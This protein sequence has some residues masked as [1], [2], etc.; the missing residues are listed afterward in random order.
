MLIK[1]FFFILSNITVPGFDLNL[2]EMGS[3]E[4][5]NAN[6][7]EGGVRFYPIIFGNLKI[8]LQTNASRNATHRT[9]SL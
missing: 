1:V 3:E 5:R 8:T 7:A 4:H 6:H 2:W 9:S